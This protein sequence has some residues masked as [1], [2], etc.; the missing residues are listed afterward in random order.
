[1]RASTRLLVG[2][3]FDGTLTE[4]A[5]HPDQATLTTRTHVA[6]A[7]LVALPGVE[8]GILSG[9]QLDDL[10]ARVPFDGVFLSGTAGLETLDVHGRRRLHISDAEA[11]PASLRESMREWCTRFDGAWLEDKGPAFAVHYRGVPERFQPAF[12]SGLRRRFA[13]ER[14][15]ARL[16]HGK[17]VFEVM[18]AVLRDKSHAFAEWVDGTGAA[19]AFYMGDDSHDETVYPRVRERAGFA[20][21]IGRNA[22][23]AEYALG[24]PQQV[25]WFLEW[26]EREWSEAKRTDAVSTGPAAEA[27]APLSA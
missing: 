23:R 20:V 16:L 7:R 15:R 21:A 10:R 1:M 14:E 26:L 8:L 9:R 3:D 24:C 13:G 5:P 12:C 25:T 17:K 6:L 11:L 27:R 4:I 19:M 2:S 18:P 22:S